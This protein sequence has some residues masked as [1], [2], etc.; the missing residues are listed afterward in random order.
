MLADNRDQTEG[1]VQL[2]RVLSSY[3]G[4]VQVGQSLAE[5]VRARVC[6]RQST[7]LTGR[8]KNSTAASDKQLGLRLFER[9][10]RRNENLSVGS[11]Q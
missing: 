8:L 4:T 2:M 6:T 9:G 1:N 7:Q 10:V 11:Y 3:N 5:A